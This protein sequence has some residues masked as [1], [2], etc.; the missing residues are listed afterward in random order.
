MSDD[1]VA[2]RLGRNRAVRAKVINDL[3]GQDF[4]NT[5]PK[6][7]R[8]L[9][10]A[11][12]DDDAAIMGEERLKVEGRNADTNERVVAIAAEL[13]RQ[14]PGRDI[15]AV[16]PADKTLGTESDIEGECKVVP[17]GPKVNLADLGDFTITD[18]ETEAISDPEDLDTFMSRFPD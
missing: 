13:A 3:S 12:K 15:L 10:A 5:D 16:K 6:I 9:L 14:T 2:S 17:E 11:L 1:T 7:T 18:G 4:A 8:V